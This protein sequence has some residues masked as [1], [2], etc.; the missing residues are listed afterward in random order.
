MKTTTI[1]KQLVIICSLF[2]GTALAQTKTIAMQDFDNVST[3]NIVGLDFGGEIL[4]G[5]STTADSPADKSYSI[6]GNCLAVAG[7]TTLATFENQTNLGSDPYKF[8]S[9]RLGAWSVGST[10]SGLDGN[11]TV[12]VE[13]ST[14]GGTTWSKELIVRGTVN[15]RWSYDLGKATAFVACDG[16]NIPIILKPGE[17]GGIKAVDGYSTVK[18][19]LPSGCTQAQ[20]R[21]LMYS[22]EVTER[23]TIDNVKLESS[24]TLDKE[25]QTIMFSA[26]P[27]KQVGDAPFTITA[28]STS[29]LP[30]IITSSDSNIATITGNTV[31]IHAGGITHL[32][33]SQ[34]GNDYFNA[35]KDST[36]TLTIAAS[37]TIVG[38]DMGSVTNLAVIPT[39]D[40]TTNDVGLAKTTLSRGAGLVGIKSNK[41]FI[42]SSWN[43]VSLTP[44]DGSVE[45]TKANALTSGD[46]YEFTVQP[47]VD[48]KL[49]LSVLDCMIFRNKA[50]SPKTYI[51]MYSTDNGANFKEISTETTYNGLDVNGLDQPSVDLSNFAELQNIMSS[52]KAIFRL[53]AWGATAAGNFGFGKPT[54]AG[55]YSLAL[56][57]VVTGPDGINEA[58]STPDFRVLNNRVIPVSG[59]AFTVFAIDGSRIAETSYSQNGIVLRKGIYI[60]KSA[61][62]VQKIIIR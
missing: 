54:T 56:R 38:W 14:D 42:S 49:S 50:E 27:K 51:W 10:S 6:S 35:A 1:L 3:L 28:V 40:A 2:V 53:Y 55:T 31:T 62:T 21:I 9:F 58:K 29:G 37:P 46:Y 47:L 52:S 30:L 59:A 20:L 36:V 19:L 24:T 12:R 26:I 32:T 4:T 25:N 16:D 13:I 48:K 61:K 18:L 33:A 60:V 34:A 8:F 15:S 44:G 23:W 39:L 57:G 5:T 43:F 45:G 11:D 7:D 17:T 22:N 41:S